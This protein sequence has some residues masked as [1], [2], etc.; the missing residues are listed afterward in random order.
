[1]Y[2]CPHCN[3]PGISALRRSFLG[4]L[5]PATCK[6][7]GGKI[8]VPFGKSFLAASSFILAI[9][10]SPLAHT[11]AYSLLTVIVGAA[12]MFVLHFKFVPLIKR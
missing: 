5:I 9:L 7:C 3:Q 11:P 4:P 6:V 12:A 8:G 1:M 2:V 10:I